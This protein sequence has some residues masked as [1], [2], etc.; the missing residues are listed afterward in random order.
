MI[1]LH[2]YVATT[3]MKVEKH[4]S[5]MGEVGAPKRTDWW[6]AGSTHKLTLEIQN[7]PFMINEE[8]DKTREQ[9]DG[10][11]QRLLHHQ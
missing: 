1:F 7:Y 11:R 9:I 4:F 10:G 2:I 5:G 6:E 3:L 8:S